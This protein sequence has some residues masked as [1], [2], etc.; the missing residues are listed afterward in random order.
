LRFPPSEKAQFVTECGIDPP[1]AFQAEGGFCFLRLI[2][3]ATS[4][5]A[6]RVIAVVAFCAGSCTQGLRV[7]IAAGSAAMIDSAAAFISNAWV[8]TVVARKPVIGGMALSAIQAE[9]ACME[10]RVAM[11]TC[12]GSG[13]TSELG[14]GMALRAIYPGVTS[15]QREV[16]FIVIEC[17]VFPTGG[18]MAGCTV[19]AKFASM[20]IVLLM[21]GETI[22]RCAFVNII[23]MTLFTAR[24]GMFALE[25]EGG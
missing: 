11:T 10:D 5:F 9:H 14:V 24:F 12:A 23:L 7:A 15:C 2:V 1:A 20:F 8:G 22:C 19:C 13:E 3:P 25:F 16:G 18:L 17:Y 4:T 21:T 6:F